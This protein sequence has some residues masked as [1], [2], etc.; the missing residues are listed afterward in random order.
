[1]DP[2]SVLRLWV[3]Q[4]AGGEDR[5][6]GRG[7]GGLP[8]SSRGLGQPQALLRPECLKRE[9]P[10]EGGGELKFPDNSDAAGRCL[11]PACLGD[12]SPGFQARGVP[13]THL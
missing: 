10:A 8:V 4:A 12:K 7:Q 6:A 2:L 9:N 1:M 13:D 5:E 11:T 3:V